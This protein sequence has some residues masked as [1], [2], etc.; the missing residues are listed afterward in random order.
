M[1]KKI[2]F[3]SG[4]TSGFG[5]ATAELFAKN[6]YSLILTGRREDR[7]KKIA[8]DLSEQYNVEVL[9]LCFDIRDQKAVEKAVLS[10]GESWKSI[11]VLV[12]NAGLASGFGLI[13]DGEIDDWEKMI[14]TNV[15]GLLY[16][17]KAI[18]PLMIA[19]KSG[20]IINIGSTA[21]K[22]VYLNGN[23]YCATKH[24]VDAI[25]KSMR[26]D[27]L[28]HGIK[29]TQ[30]CPGA[31]ETEFSE[32]RFHGDKERAKSVYKGYQPM[33]A[34]DIASL[35]YFAATLPPHLCINDLVVTSLAQANSFYFDRK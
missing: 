15:K 20:H 16:L 8:K 23:V 31:A 26:I 12:N 24:A 5:K 18:M 21:G 11:D 9:P 14:D 27:L 10:L 2:V 17:S 13:Q 6:N 29:V 34:E 22:E 19:N 28:Q 4:A 35:I 7:L 30:I 33:M 25:S 3:I 1:T 32:V